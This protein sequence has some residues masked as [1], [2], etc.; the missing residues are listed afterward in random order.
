MRIIVLNK[1]SSLVV[2]GVETVVRDHSASLAQD[3]HDCIILCSASVSTPRQPFSYEIRK[4]RPGCIEVE[5]STIFKHGA[6]TFSVALAIVFLALLRK[7]SSQKISLYYHDPSPIFWPLLMFAG[8]SLSLVAYWHAELVSFRR[9]HP[10][11]NFFRKKIFNK[12]ELN[13][14]SNVNTMTAIT[15]SLSNGSYKGLSHIVPLAVSQDPANFLPPEQTSIP[16]DL[17]KEYHL[18]LGR[19]CYYK[20]LALLLKALEHNL[21]VGMIPIVIVGEASDET[22]QLILD[23]LKEFENVHHINMFVSNVQKYQL[24]KNAYSFLFLSDMV[25]EAYGITQVEALALG[26]PVVNLNISSGVPLVIDLDGKTC[27]IT[28]NVDDQTVR[29]LVNFL[30][31]GFIED[32][33][34]LS[35]RARYKYLR[36]YAPEKISRKIQNLFETLK[37]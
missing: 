24:I 4:I 1:F 21:T 32:R 35:E 34:I 16:F 17:P 13:I 3:G 29:S 6:F 31:M 28:F 15:K 30:N 10:F 7:Y 26:T 19:L 23:K 18:I 11:I 37:K 27:G 20:G 14:F 9:L 22:S 36:D 5:C 12:C 8:S 25:A 2:G 33:S